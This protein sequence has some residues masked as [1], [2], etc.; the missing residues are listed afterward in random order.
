MNAKKVQMSNALNELREFGLININY[1]DELRQSVE[2][3]VKSWKN[4]CYLP[5]EEK[6]AFAFLEDNH[7]DGS[8]YELKEDKGWKKDLKENFHVTLFQYDRLI[9][10]ANQRTFSFLNDVKILLDKIE[11][12]I[13]EFSHAVEEEYKIDGLLKEVKSSKSHWIL[14]YLHYFGDQQERFEIAAPHVD[15]GVLLSTF[16]KVMRDYNI[17]V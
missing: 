1:P 7:G 9:Q 10:I 4:F 6:L 2:E 15:K 13:L 3:A 8:G 14:R 12:L 17:T 5:A 11:P 16:L